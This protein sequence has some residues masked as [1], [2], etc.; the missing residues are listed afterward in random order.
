MIFVQVIAPLGLILNR[1]K[2]HNFCEF[3]KILFS[4]QKIKEHLESEAFLHFPIKAGCQR[5]GLK[6]YSFQLNNTTKPIAECQCQG[7]TFISY[8]FSN[9][10]FIISIRM[11]WSILFP[12]IST[13]IA[14]N[15]ELLEV[16]SEHDLNHFPE[17]IRL[18]ILA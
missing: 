12:S 11:L 6:I 8:L 1:K 18:I 14:A 4:T 16:I 2:I 7:N 3:W 17:Q 15:Y 10:K 13:L 9:N 5:C